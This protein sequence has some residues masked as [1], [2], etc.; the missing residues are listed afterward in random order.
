MGTQAQAPP[1]DG[2]P[3]N[4]IRNSQRQVRW[5][6]CQKDQCHLREGHERA[7]FNR[8]NQEEGETVEVCIWK[9]AYGNL[10]EEI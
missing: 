6:L 1:I 7:M 4:G 3:T 5:T 2:R 10:R 8:R 9:S